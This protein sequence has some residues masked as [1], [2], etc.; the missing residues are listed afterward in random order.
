MSLDFLNFRNYN[1]IDNYLI[2]DLKNIILEYTELNWCN[3]EITKIFLFHLTLDYK[4]YNFARSESK[5]DI[6]TLDKMYSYTVTD[7]HELDKIDIHQNIDSIE[8]YIFS[9]KNLVPQDNL[10]FHLKENKY[11]LLSII[12][13]RII[14]TNNTVYIAKTKVKNNI[15]DLLTIKNSKKDYKI[16][17]MIKNRIIESLRAGIYKK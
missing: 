16:R 2:N 1:S 3:E 14:G 13:N 5:I 4:K 8:T 17:L 7:Y 9:L 11:V 15:Y 10:K 12:E 6:N